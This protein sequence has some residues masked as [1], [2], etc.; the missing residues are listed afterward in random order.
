MVWQSLEQ[1]R[2][3][4]I[5]AFDPSRGEPVI[6]ATHQAFVAAR[7]G[8]SSERLAAPRLSDVALSLLP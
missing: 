6:S 4:C 1:P 2:A 3:V 8:P 7:E 5:S